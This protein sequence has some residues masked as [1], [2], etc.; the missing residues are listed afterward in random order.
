MG[1]RAAREEAKLS[2]V[3]VGDEVGEVKTWALLTAVRKK[4]SLAMTTQNQG[5]WAVALIAPK[6][7]RPGEMTSALCTLVW[8]CNLLLRGQSALIKCLQG[9]LRSLGGRWW[10][11]AKHCY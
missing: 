4:C 2:L 5:S 1:M 6:S 9:L 3:R 8:K 10:R 7:Q 11:R